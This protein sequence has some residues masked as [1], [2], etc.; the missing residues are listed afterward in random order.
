[1]I[2]EPVANGA[3]RKRGKHAR[4]SHAANKE[5]AGDGNGDRPG[6][7]INPDDDIPEKVGCSLNEEHLAA[8]YQPP[9]RLG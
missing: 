7:G 9:V 1:M 6:V 4:D 5:H 8:L 3:F 2:V